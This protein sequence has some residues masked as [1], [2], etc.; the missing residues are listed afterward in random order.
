MQSTATVYAKPAMRD[1]AMMTDA[2]NA[3]LVIQLHRRN[4]PAIAMR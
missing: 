4:A 2:Q 1:V 3:E